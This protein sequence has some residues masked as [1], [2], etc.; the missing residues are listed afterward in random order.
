[1]RNPVRFTIAFLVAVVIGY[2]GFAQDANAFFGRHRGHYGC[3]G[4]PAASCSGEAHAEAGCSGEGW[5]WGKHR[6]ER[7]ARR[8]VR[9]AES[10]GCGGEA[11]ASCGGVSASCAGGGYVEAP[12]PVSYAAP[13]P[14]CPNGVCPLPPAAATATC[15]N[16]GH[17]GCTGD[18]SCPCCGPTCDCG[19]PRYAAA[20]PADAPHVVPSPPQTP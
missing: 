15:P 8:L 7:H 10:Y 3:S 14:N 19:K 13:C 1:M 6:D 18:A 4:A 17:A 16:C 11:A 12:A 9:H 20:T 2:V 5:Y